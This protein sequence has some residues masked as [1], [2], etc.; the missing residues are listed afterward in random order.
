M[1]TSSPL[2]FSRLPVLEPWLGHAYRAFPIRLKHYC[3]F[4]VEDSVKI[5]CFAL[6]VAFGFAHA[7]LPT[8]VFPCHLC[9]SAPRLLRQLRRGQAR[10]LYVLYLQG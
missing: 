6:R 1:Q 7:M 8:P 10:S 9:P 2:P 4:F 5:G 3:V